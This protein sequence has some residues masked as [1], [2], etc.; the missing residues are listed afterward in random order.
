[1]SEKLKIYV[2]IKKIKQHNGKEFYKATVPLNLI[3]EKEF[4]AKSLEK[5]ISILEK[6]YS[7]LITNLKALLAK[8]Q[9]K[10][11]KD[12]RI[13]L[14]WKFGDEI[15]NFINHVNKKSFHIEKLTDILMHDVGASIKFITRCERF[16]L[17]YPDIK[18]I[19]PK[20]SFW[21]YI[22]EFESGYLSHKNKDEQ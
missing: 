5:E 2:Q 17:L 7:R 14:Y 13:L 18:M 12:G 22:V 9:N 16:K 19:D 3:F 8:I 4:N 6:D 20:R 21:S 11:N 10:S 1:M 15:I